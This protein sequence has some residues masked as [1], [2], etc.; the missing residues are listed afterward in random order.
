MIKLALALAL[1][2]CGGNGVDNGGGGDDVAVDGSVSAHHGFITLQTYDGTLSGAPVVD[3]AV[4]AS[5]VAVPACTSQT[6]GPCEYKKCSAATASKNA[7]PITIAGLRAPVTLTLGPTMYTQY[8]AMAALFEGGEHATVSAPGAELEAFSATLTTP[9][10]PT[11]TSPITA[12]TDTLA[13]P[14]THDFTATWVATTSPIV[15]EVI[16]SDGGSLRCLYD[17]AAGSGTIPAS[18]LALLSPGS[19]G[20]SMLAVTDTVVTSGDWEIT[21]SCYFLANLPDG[22]LAGAS[23]MVQ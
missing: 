3:G 2:A 15:V 11:M 22:S 17:G 5:F 12:V 20:Y 13:I 8:N 1:A 19:G 6:A 14:R 21:I 18:A 10:R 4:S 16:G 23:A 7:G 9:K